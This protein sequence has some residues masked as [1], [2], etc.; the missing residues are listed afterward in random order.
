MRMVLVCIGGLEIDSR[1][2]P[3]V[4]VFLFIS[5]LCLSLMSYLYVMNT[6]ARGFPLF[7][8]VSRGLEVSYCFAD[9]L[10]HSL[11]L[12]HTKSSGFFLFFSHYL[13]GLI[14]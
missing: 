8:R 13:I 7:T 11:L 10:I 1:E 3:M 2:R 12:T 6:Q 4:L 14:T 5:A 9:S